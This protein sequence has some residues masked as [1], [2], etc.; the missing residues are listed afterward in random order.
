MCDFEK[1]KS[2]LLCCRIVVQT[3]S[4]TLQPF[5]TRYNSRGVTLITTNTVVIHRMKKQTNKNVLVVCQS[6]FIGVKQN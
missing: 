6:W 3:G 5:L 4:L 2:E 1:K